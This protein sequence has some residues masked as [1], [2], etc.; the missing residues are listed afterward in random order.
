MN[1][2][3][4]IDKRLKNNII[5]MTA[6]LSYVINKADKKPSIE[7][8]EMIKGLTEGIANLLK[9]IEDEPKKDEK[10]EK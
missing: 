8:A 7:K 10:N 2:K 6:S 9:V 3:D 4:Q 1:F 5:E